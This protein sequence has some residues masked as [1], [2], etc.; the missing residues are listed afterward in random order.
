[1]AKRGSEHFRPE[2]EDPDADQMAV[3]TL[4]TSVFTGISFVVA[5]IIYSFTGTLVLKLAAGAERTAAMIAF[6]V[7]LAVGGG[8]VAFLLRRYSTQIQA[9]S[10]NLYRGAWI[11]SVAAMVIIVVMYYD[12][13][14]VIPRYCPPGTVC[15]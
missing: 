10:K 1:M 7:G 14:I 5:V 2:P 15:Q 11:G 8:L 9:R 3:A 12:P 13:G 4:M 6:A